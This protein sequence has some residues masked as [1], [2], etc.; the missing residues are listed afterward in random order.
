MKCKI[1]EVRK[2]RRWCPGVGGDICSQCCGTEREVTVDCPFECE[3]L[4]QAWQHEKP[5]QQMA[6]E[7]VPNRD[8]RITDQFFR[9]QEELITVLCAI[10]LEAAMDVSGAVDY[11]VREAL[12]ALI[13]TY[14]T[15]Q[16]GLFYETKPDNPLASAIQQG[17]QERVEE[18]R[19]KL[20]KNG[21]PSVRDAD[22][23]GGLV[24]LQ[25]AELK[26]DHGRRRGRAFLGSL[27]SMFPKI[28]PPE[29]RGTLI[30]I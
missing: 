6:P 30:Q 14:R 3:Y 20:V 16:S 4:Q 29:D 9:E 11:D 18:M 24:F 13:R 10:L 21:R 12:E 17:F 28:Q 25:R 1:C 5:P 15:L 19:E 2:P 8:I 26:H 27:R 22:V 23:L 7:Q